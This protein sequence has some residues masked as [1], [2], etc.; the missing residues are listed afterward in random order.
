MSLAYRTVGWNAQKR[1]YDA[2]AGGGVIGYLAMFL[3][4]QAALR[5]ELTIETLLIRAFGSA[6]LVLLHVVLAIGPLTRLDR[7]FLPLLY[8]RRHLGVMTFSLGLAHGLFA[9]VQFHAFGPLDP[10]VSVFVSNPR[11]DAAF[12]PLAQIAH[13]PFQ[14]FGLFALIILF[15]MA[16]TSHDFWL[17]NLTAP[18]WKAM[19]MGVYAAYASLVLHVMFG[20]LQGETHPALAW[21]LAAAAAGLLSLHVAAAMREA[22][23]DVMADTAAMADA[24]VM[25]DRG[26]PYVDVCAV[27]DI[28]ERRAVITCLSGERVAIFRY[29]GKVSALSNVCQH[30]NGPLGEGR[31]VNDCVV[32]PWHGYEYLPDSGASPPPFTEKVPTFNVR[33][34]DGRVFVDPRPNPPGT[35]VA[36]VLIELETSTR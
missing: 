25:A 8:N 19:H 17:H 5:P 14:P 30:Q 1:R 3:A 12:A 32:C 33:L 13:V 27:G 24:A 34:I 16:A 15:L 9:L 22:R 31:I 35:R 36:P 20:V 21:M 28:P 29:D 11:Y 26:A 6:A 7:R 4:V 18:V 2:I 10:L 23:A